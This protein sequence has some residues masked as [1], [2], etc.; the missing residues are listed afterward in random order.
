MSV[1]D[2]Q[3]LGSVSAGNKEESIFRVFAYLNT[4]EEFSPIVIQQKVL[5]KPATIVGYLKT[6]QK[7]QFFDKDY[8]ERLKLPFEKQIFAN[9]PGEQKEIA[10]R[11][12][13]SWKKDSNEAELESW[14]N[15]NLHLKQ[16]VYSYNP[17]VSKNEFYSRL[18]QSILIYEFLKKKQKN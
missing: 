13:I 12:F 14:E 4:R 11:C 17:Y 10:E 9:A 2:L 1:Q 7:A 6:I 5:V 18:E 16:Y 8:I 15:K 3:Q